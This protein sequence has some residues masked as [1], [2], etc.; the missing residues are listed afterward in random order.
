MVSESKSNS[1]FQPK[2][3]RK[4]TLKIIFTLSNSVVLNFELTKCSNILHCHLNRW[5]T[6][7]KTSHSVIRLTPPPVSCEWI[8]WVKKRR[9]NWKPFAFLQFTMQRMRADGKSDK[10]YNFKLFNILAAKAL[11]HVFIHLSIH[12]FFWGSGLYFSAFLLGSRFLCGF[13]R[14]NALAVKMSDCL[15]RPLCT[16]HAPYVLLHLC[17][18]IIEMEEKNIYKWSACILLEINYHSTQLLITTITNTI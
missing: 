5:M 13:A 2:W 6:G 17:S 4:F 14:S 10:L 3:H 16:L 9:R 11:F 18:W 12:V 1:K 15:L 8:I 7:G